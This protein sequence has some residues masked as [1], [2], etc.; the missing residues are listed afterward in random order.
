MKARKQKLQSACNRQTDLFQYYS[1]LPYESPL[2]HLAPFMLQQAQTREQMN[3]YFLIIVLEC[4]FGSKEKSAP[5]EGGWRRKLLWGE[6]G[7]DMIY[8]FFSYV[9]RVRIFGSLVSNTAGF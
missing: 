8:F 7:R 3:K 6:K 4:F 1:C 5:E 9:L 2:I